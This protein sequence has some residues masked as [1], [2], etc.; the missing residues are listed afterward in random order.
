MK[1]S[2]LRGY[3]SE[4]MAAEGPGR[5]SVLLEYLVYEMERASVA[6]GSE[7]SSRSRTLQS[8]SGWASRAQNAGSRNR[9][10]TPYTTP[11]TPET[12]VMS[13]TEAGKELGSFVASTLPHLTV[14]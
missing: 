4:D 14:R 3:P 1:R 11:N 9:G 2:L 7:A 5:E 8:V 12:L 13:E 6:V 10:M